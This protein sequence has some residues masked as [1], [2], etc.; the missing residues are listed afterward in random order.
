[1]THCLECENLKRVY[2]S[3]LTK[4]LGARSAV[5]YRISTEVAAKHQ[6]SMERAKNDLEEHR[7]ICP[8]VTNVSEILALV[9]LQE[10]RAWSLD[11]KRQLWEQPRTAQAK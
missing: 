10:S 7:L 11:W 5:L 9:P 6:V 3:K 8:L 4:Y 2:E 1:M